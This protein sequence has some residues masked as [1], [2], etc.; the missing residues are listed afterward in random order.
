MDY[1]MNTEDPIEIVVYTDPLCCWSAALQ[2]HINR[3]REELKVPINLRYCISGMIADWNS[4]TDPINSIQKPA[5]MGPVWME[6]KHITG[7]EID[8]SIWVKDPP[9]SSFP[10]SIAIKTAGLQSPEAEEK[11]LFAL[12]DAVMKKGLNISK[13]TVLSKVAND[14]AIEFPELFNVKRFIKEYNQ[15]EC[16]DSLRKDMNEV[17]Q[18]HIGRFPTLTVRKNGYQSIMIT[19]YRPYDVLLSAFSYL[20]P[21]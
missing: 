13:N 11:M 20:N 9:S 1:T 19:G 8:D 16:R 15:S 18:H 21:N 17:K 2:P 7:A 10:A 12:R 5:Q 4:F 6:A 14:L 3:L